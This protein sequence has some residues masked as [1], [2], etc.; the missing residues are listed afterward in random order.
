MLSAI[1]E[2]QRIAMKLK[3]AT[4]L[5]IIGIIIQLIP[6]IIYSMINLGLTSYESW[7]MD[8]LGL[9]DTIGTAMML[10]FFIS[11]YKKQQ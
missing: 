6:N 11:L 3:N 1:A 8:F 7:P 2:S 5:V 10:P 9:F 4:Q